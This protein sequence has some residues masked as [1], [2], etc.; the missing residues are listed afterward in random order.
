[1]EELFAEILHWMH[2]RGDTIGTT[3]VLSC[4]RWSKL[5][6]MEFE[7]P[8]VVIGNGK[9]SNLYFADYRAVEIDG[10]FIH[11]AGKDTN[12]YTDVT[13]LTNVEIS[14][15]QN[16]SSSQIPVFSINVKFRARVYR[17]FFVSI[18]EPGLKFK[19]FGDVQLLLCTFAENVDIEDTRFDVSKIIFMTKVFKDNTVFNKPL[20]WNTKNI[21][22]MAH[23]FNNSKYSQ[24]IYW[25]LRNAISIDYMF[26]N[27]PIKD[28]WMYTPSLNRARNI[29]SHK[30][31][32]FTLHRN[33]IIEEITLKKSLYDG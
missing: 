21:Y 14:Q 25:D 23:M 30:P 24:K 17:P 6:G 5:G 10:T 31:E 19:T 11:L 8:T 2:Q 4:R 20:F 1:M 18:K 13:C 26:L 33:L 12:M 29:L 7:Q 9:P 15:F 28:V 22:M 3:R 16:P 32:K 27:C